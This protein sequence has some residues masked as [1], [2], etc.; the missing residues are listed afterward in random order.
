MKES[1][2]ELYIILNEESMANPTKNLQIVKVQKIFVNVVA[3]HVIAPTK[4]FPM[5]D[6][7]LP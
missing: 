2:N 6:G 1:S 5:S 7:I 3:I 4:C